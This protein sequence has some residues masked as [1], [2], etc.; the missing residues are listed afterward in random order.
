MH[1]KSEFYFHWRLGLLLFVWGADVLWALS[2]FCI[3]W[4]M[5]GTWAGGEATRGRK[6][7]QWGHLFV[8]SAALPRSLSRID[9]ELFSLSRQSEMRISDEKGEFQ[10]LRRRDARLT[11]FQLLTRRAT[12]NILVRFHLFQRQS[13]ARELLNCRRASIQM[14][15]APKST[16]SHLIHFYIYKVLK[17]ICRPLLMSSIKDYLSS[18]IHE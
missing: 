15:F 4:G 16:L 10:V 17:R 11:H 13:L 2:I 14:R 3:I 7:L 9:T 8:F 18:S 12:E 6:L 5:H 1:T